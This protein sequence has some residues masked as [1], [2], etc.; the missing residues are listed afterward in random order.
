M[1]ADPVLADHREL[2]SGELA[3]VLRLIDSATDTDGVSPVSEHV[4][5]HL[6]HGGDGEAHNLLVH[7]DGGA[8][9]GYAHLDLTDLVGGGAAE[10]VVSPEHRRGGLGA[11]LVHAL[12]EFT[13]D[14]RLRLWA[15]GR[16]P[17]ARALAERLGYRQ[18]RVL[19]QLRR[20][21]LSGLPAVDVPQ[22]VTIRPFVVGQDEQVW[23]DVNNRAFADHPDQGGWS[24]NQIQTREKEPWFDPE[25]FLLAVDDEDRLLGFHWT[26]V[27]GGGHEHPGSGAHAHE[28]IGE[29]YA[30]GVDPGAQGRGL[31]PVL[32]AAGLRYL[33]GLGL[34]QVMLYVDES[35]AGAVRLYEKLGFTHWDLDVSYRRP[36]PDGG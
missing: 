5:L 25:G 19:F 14:G 30:L 7:D 17:G 36:G 31:G 12:E 29:V 3:E 6:R 28:P 10:L 8:L 22:G 21:L 34:S 11:H 16:T 2:E 33:R 1:S 9:T 32:T 15:H 18:A 35:N 24:L 23:T 4:L 27:H 26:K 13:T 20:S